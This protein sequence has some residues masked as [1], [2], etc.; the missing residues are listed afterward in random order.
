M[1]RCQTAG[2]VA[3][4]SLDFSDKWRS[5]VNVTPRPLYPQESTAISSDVGAETTPERVWA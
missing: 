2:G 1:P 3:P 4:L 5:D